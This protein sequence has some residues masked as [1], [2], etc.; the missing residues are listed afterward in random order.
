MYSRA[1]LLTSTRASPAAV[2]VVLHTI[3]LALAH[4]A[5]R[6]APPMRH[7]ST[8]SDSDADEK[9]PPC[10]VS[11]VP[12]S[13]APRDGHTDD[14][15]ADGTYVNSTPDDENC[16]PFSDTSTRR[17]PAPTD[18]DDAHSSTPA[19]TTRPTAVAPPSSNR[20]RADADSRSRA[21]STD[22]RV[23]PPTGPTSGNAALTHTRACT[24]KLPPL[25]SV[26]PALRKAPRQ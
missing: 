16:T 17:A 9:P 20:H 22:T 6:T 4:T 11:G 10:T 3:A 12:P 8:P 19:D 25:R 21:P 24:R 26:P 13:A 5:R 7:V 15:D 18:A 1:L 23:P 14:T 2:R